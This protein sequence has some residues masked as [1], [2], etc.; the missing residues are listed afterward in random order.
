ML[1]LSEPSSGLLFFSFLY[2]SDFFSQSSLQAQV[3]SRFGKG[4]VLLPAFNPLAEYYAREMGEMSELKRFFLV[5][6]TSYPREF[7]LTAK[8]QAL[9]WE[10]LWSANCKRQVNVDVGLI[11][12]ESFILATTKN[13]SHRIFI[14][15]RIF[16]DLTYQFT[17][18]RFQ[19]LPWCYPD[20]R[21]QEKI[22]FI[23]WCRSFLLV[24]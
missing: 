5:T 2:R 1:E 11:T 9:N 20:Y 14:G 16:A 19:P 22:D 7:L 23:T 21:D 18:N 3:E 8:L 15:Q 6:S 24:K 4:F 13:Y 10:K 17:E 12:A